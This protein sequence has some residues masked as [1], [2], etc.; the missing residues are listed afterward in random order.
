M[1][2]HA[3]S[4]NVLDD[5][6]TT[7]SD[8]S[9]RPDP[10]GSGDRFNL[11]LPSVLQQRLA[12]DADSQWW[13]AEGSAV[14]VDIS[15][16]TKLSERLARKG[17]E[18]SEQITEAIGNSFESLLELAYDNGGSLL[19]FGGDALLLWFEVPDHAA[20]ACRAALLMRRRLRTV[21]RI[22]VPGAKVNLRMTQG[23]HSGEFHFFSVGTSHR[24]FL[25]LGASWSRVVEMEHAADAGEI[26]VSAETAALLPARCLGAARE[27]GYLLL[28]EPPN[29]A[30]KLPLRKRPPIDPET[31][32]RGL[33]PAIRAHVREGGGAA[34]HRPVSI[35]FIHFDGT[36]ALIE[37]E[38]PEVAARALHELVSAIEAATEAQDVAL[39]GSDVDSDGGKII[40]TA[41]APKATGD[42]EQ[43]MLLA[44]RH[45][46]DARPSIPIRIGTHRGAVFAGDIGPFY[47]R[48]Y[49]V[50][51]DAV[52]LSARLMAKAS[53]GT[54]YA[55]A[56][57]LNRS[58]TLFNVTE[59]E[60]FM[61]KGKAQPIRA[62]SVG[63]AMGSRTR[64][65][66]VQQLELIGR[67]E[68]LHTLREALDG[69][70]QGNGRMVEI[71]GETG[72]GKTRL[73]HALKENATGFQTLHAVCEAYT[74]STPY[75]LWRE[76]LR[77]CMGFSRDDDDKA[78]EVRL[79]EV[80]A[81]KTPDLALWLPLL[82]IV[83]GLD[84]EMTP[85]V[86][87]LT[88][89]N[90]KAKLHETTLEFLGAILAS[91]GLVVVDNAHHIDRASAELLAYLSTAIGSRP[92]VVGVG[93]R[94]QSAFAAPKGGA[95]IRIEL[96]PLAAGDALCMARGASEH[97]PLPPHVV[98]T[99]AS[100]SG[101]NPQFLRD[102]VRAA[103]ASG[104]IGGLPECAEAATMARI[105]ALSPDDRW[106]LRR[107]AFFGMTFHPR[108]VLWLYPEG[109]RLPDSGVWSRLASL[110][111]EEPD[112]YLRFGRS[113]LRDA[114]Y[115]GLPYKLR[116][117]LHGVV[118]WNLEDESGEKADEFA[119]MLSLHYLEAGN[120]SSALHYAKIAARRAQAIYAYVEAAELYARALAASCNLVDLADKDVAEMHAAEA[121]CWY[122]AA[123]Y[124]KASASYMSAYRLMK[125]NPVSAA[126]LLL[127]RSRVE[128]KLGKLRHALTWAARARKA[129]KEFDEPEAVR[130]DAR[131][132]SWY[133]S[134]LQREG[135]TRHA[136]R[137]A[138][139]AVAAAE[140]VDDA[141]A[142]GAAYYVL[143]A[144]N[145]DR[146][147]LERSLEAYRRSGNLQRQAALLSDLGVQC[148]FAGD[149]SEALAYYQRSREESMKI[150]SAVSAAL[151]R[152]N[153]AEIL[154]DRGELAEAEEHLLDIL[155]LWKASRYRFLLAHCVSLLG[156]LSL[157]AGRFEE[158]LK[159]F[160]EARADFEHV[161]AAEE[162]PAVDTRI[163]ECWVNMGDGHAALAQIDGVMNRATASAKA[164]LVPLMKRVRAFALQQGGDVSSAREELQASLG[165]ARAAK[166]LFE[167]AQTLLSMIELC[168]RQRAE[169]P[170]EVVTEMRAL[171]DKLKIRVPPSIPFTATNEI[172]GQAA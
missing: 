129:V 151:A 4:I 6:I 164:K 56:D 170:I 160:Q 126:E 24:E 48:T 22:E 118:A 105:D 2:S 45:I 149:W 122:K 138:K 87:M 63:K 155:P 136:L 69:A 108:M 135:R 79:R 7:N 104:G 81:A 103:I 139:Q 116:R 26:M 23:V 131:A 71:V 115:E 150:G 64:E 162:V 50:M 94:G 78:V 60:P 11:Y 134:L 140:A 157:R 52:N 112:G 44:L 36:D 38:G 37:R 31:L 167:I 47:R 159:R 41:G 153:I 16:F 75:A 110:F 147:M 25:P 35:A 165:A 18:G 96:K 40:L 144:L 84:F 17:R 171:F 130:Q 54:I 12:S 169:P 39:L 65:V 98:E 21:G 8:P 117:Q 161:G 111:E 114:A 42:D 141:D 156:R 113:L 121:E 15:G 61:V 100:R 102:L 148:W 106:L 68:E 80:V 51:G 3:V 82:A 128:E 99:I 137:W 43:R 77:E 58:D 93:H 5:P 13:T 163:A 154:I 59:L 9:I 97:Y 70:R 120:C 142:L 67:D 158:A 143:G 76:L 20:R 145:S 86:E 28:R 10:A 19:K 85:E 32:A 90:R 133:A 152:I 57:I 62:W 119:G 55:T 46:I 132:A 95:T 127:K 89:A 168:R 91:P 107:L 73:L 166:D 125:A 1:S 123:E 146:E 66:S 101:G 72:L 53:P 49:T 124:A 33:S 27:S 83:L 92:W 109:E 14:F 88:D 172:A 30:D 34:E 74:A 29:V